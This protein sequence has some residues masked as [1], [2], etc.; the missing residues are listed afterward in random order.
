[1]AV[2]PVGLSMEKGKHVS[3]GKTANPVQLLLSVSFNAL[4]AAALGK[5]FM[6]LLDCSHLPQQSQET[7]VPAKTECTK[8]PFQSF[9][10]WLMKLVGCSDELS[11][12]HPFLG[13]NLNCGLST[14]PQQA[15]VLPFESP[16]P[17]LDLCIFRGGE[18]SLTQPGMLQNRVPP[19]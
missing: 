9:Y 1:M 5:C 11:I 18:L 3:L 14:S 12:H 6:R 2:Y 15:P 7:L 8:C 17:H 16:E 13:T 10:T 19:E 4:K